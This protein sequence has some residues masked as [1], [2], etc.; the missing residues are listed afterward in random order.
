MRGQDYI[1][2]DQLDGDGS[3]NQAVYYTCHSRELCC[4][5]YYYILLQSDGIVMI[6]LLL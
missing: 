6:I 2:D 5:L 3:R 4:R 1:C